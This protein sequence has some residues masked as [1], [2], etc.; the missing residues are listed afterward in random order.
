[1]G[2]DNSKNHL[3]QLLY[4]YLFQKKIQKYLIKN[5]NEKEGYKNEKGY[6]IHPYW[7]EK[8]K[9]TLDYNFFKNHLNLMNIESIYITEEQKESIIDIM[10]YKNIQFYSEND[11]N[12]YFFNIT[13]KII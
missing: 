7:I 3:N 6:F 11:R 13:R 8:W 4:Y 10:K 9:K 5:N 1:M 12:F 2:S